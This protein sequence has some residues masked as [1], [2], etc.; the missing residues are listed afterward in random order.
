MKK[1]APS[2]FAPKN[3]SKLRG[4]KASNEIKPNLKSEIQQLILKPN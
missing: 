1:K 2:V 3:G 4:Q